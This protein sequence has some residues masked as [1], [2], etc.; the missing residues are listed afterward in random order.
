[1]LFE[2]RT[3]K[4]NLSLTQL[5]ADVSLMVGARRVLVIDNPDY[6]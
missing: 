2:A 1:M 6:E 4:R 5:P 3:T